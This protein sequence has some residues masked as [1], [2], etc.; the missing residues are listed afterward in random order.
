M[1]VPLVRMRVV[2]GT[3]LDGLRV[4]FLRHRVEVLEPSHVVTCSFCGPQARLFGAEFGYHVAV[5]V[6]GDV[7]L[8][9]LEWGGGRGG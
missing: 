2:V 4:G 6:E 1:T 5:Q 8:T 9:W 7:L 3:R